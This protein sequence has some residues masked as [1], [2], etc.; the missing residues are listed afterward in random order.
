VAVLRNEVKCLDVV[1]GEVRWAVEHGRDGMAVRVAMAPGGDR[2]GVTLVSESVSL[3]DVETGEIELTLAHPDVR[4]ITALTFDKS[5][6]R[7]CAL[8]GSVVQ[9]WKLD[10]IERRL[11]AQGMGRK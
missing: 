9:T 10:V 3:I 11:E 4:T 7:L 1:T 8:A 2:V 6:T 5:G